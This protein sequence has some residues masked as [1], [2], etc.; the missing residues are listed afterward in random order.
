MNKRNQVRIALLISLIFA[1]LFGIC[2]FILHNSADQRF[3]S[4]AN[5]MTLQIESFI[6]NNETEKAALQDSLKED[7]ISRARSLAYLLEMNPSVQEDYYELTKAA[8]LLDIDEINI[9]DTKG[10]IAYST[11]PD[12]VGFSIY[13]GGQIAFFEPMMTDKS[14]ELCQDMT[15]NTKDGKLIM[16][17]AVWRQDGDSLVEI[18]ITP[19]HLLE[20]MKRNDISK[21]LD[22]M[23]HDETMYFIYDTEQDLIV[24]STE[25][26]ILGRSN[27]ETTFDL[28]VSEDVMRKFMVEGTEY[29]YVLSDYAPY[30]IGVCERTA[31]IYKDVSSSSSILAFFL[32]FTLLG[33]YVLIVYMEDKEHRKEREYIE[34]LQDSSDKLSTYKKT[35]LADALISLE[36]N[37]T[38][39]ELYDG[40]WKDDNG[41]EVPLQDILGISMPCSYDKY[42]QLWQQKFVKK[43]QNNQFSGRTDRN[44]LLE[45]FENGTSEITLDYEAR[46]ISGKTAWL[47][48]LISMSRNQEGDVISF[49][50]VKDV[51]AE[52]MQSKREEEIVRALSNEYE[53]IAVVHFDKN[54]KNDKVVVHS[55][56]SE[57]VAALVDSDTLVEENF[58]T[59]LDF[60]MQYIHPDDKERF[61]A[62]TRREAMFAS[63]AENIT[64]VIDFRMMK[65]EGDYAFYQ[66]RFV[67]IRDDENRIYG[68]I[69]CVRSTDSEIRKE[70]GA[71]QELEAAKIAA[72]SANQAKSSFL[73]NMSHDI[74][75]PMNAII[76]F[77]D[78][79]LKHIDEK[80]RVKDSL[81]KVRASGEHLLSLINDVL[82]M[83]RVEAGRVTLDEQPLCIDAAKDNLYS[84]LAGTAAA[85][86]LTFTSVIDPS[87]EHHWIYAD[88]LC[89][90]RVLMN[91]ISN[92]IKY[93]NPGGTISLV[94][95]ELP[96][97]K[98]GFAHLRYTVTD[99]GIG[100]S[101]EFLEH[102]FEAFSRA[103]TAT[104]SGVV[105]TG[106][107]MSI[108]KSLVEM[109]GGTIKVESELG[110]GTRVTTDFVYRIAEPVTEE[111]PDD[112]A[113][114]MKLQGAKILLVEDNELNREIAT[115]ILEEEGVF[116]DT[117]EDGD[118]AVEK[119]R[120]SVPGQY[121]LILMDIQMPRMDGYTATRAIRSLCDPK[122]AM[123]PIIAMTANAFEEDKQN[124]YNA[125]MNGHLAKPI[126]VPK[127][128]KTL[129]EMLE[130]Y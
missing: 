56:V 114:Q 89:T 22:K 106:L 4:S 64:H 80:D 125:G 101:K 100:M 87:V 29:A 61:Y 53:S 57:D 103:E 11:V 68:M 49:T 107:G 88:R 63:F 28:S 48:R 19:E 32:L 38:R 130:K 1:I 91:I 102:I 42:I 122:L 105:G 93:T 99:N 59:K 111:I 116:V 113:L 77:T 30:R 33:V 92:S 12:Y 95:E 20:S 58:S 119:V 44:Y 75:T 43:D 65:P 25:E 98:E 86:D 16:Y 40:T 84:M 118:I 66:M 126:D 127:L 55:R 72:E 2:L 83:S 8:S 24:A 115:D 3:M 79:A 41:A 129:S 26:V 54:K 71:R 73:F 109:M 10:L 110:K 37:L 117:A 85:K 120:S 23:P 121:D 81:G 39:D 124:A 74:R 14:L 104:K 5:S 123:I 31:D 46:T 97:D 45:A 47:R 96:C 128:L 108:T 70:V 50:S 112:E 76:G 82:D 52:I 94:A 9:F 15:P 62:E 6:E 7:Y 78:M 27:A 36:A 90:M 18:G 13:S 35:V 67:P 51:S 34:V 21:V 60:L 69:A 17:A